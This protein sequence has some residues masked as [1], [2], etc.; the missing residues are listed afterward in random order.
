[1]WNINFSLSIFSFSASIKS[2]FQRTPGKKRF[3]LPFQDH[4]W[5]QQRCCYYFPHFS[6][7]QTGPWSNEITACLC[8]AHSRVSWKDASAT[9]LWCPEMLQIPPSSS[10]WCLRGSKNDINLLIT[11]WKRIFSKKFLEA[12]R[13][14]TPQNHQ[15]INSTWGI[16]RGIV[17]VG[18]DLG[19]RAVQEVAADSMLDGTPW[20]LLLLYISCSDSVSP[21]LF[22]SLFSLSPLLLHW[23]PYGATL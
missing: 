22:S 20:T 3:T 16:N 18:Q 12:W 21:C 17:C 23:T 1:M 14:N 13:T 6:P 11:V 5:S 8:S 19:E 4:L 10:G 2:A 9:W 15:G 7:G